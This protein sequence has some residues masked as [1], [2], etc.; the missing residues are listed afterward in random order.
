MKHLFKFLSAALL[1]SAATAIASDCNRDC[2][3][4]EYGERCKC[5]DCGST[6]YLPRPQGSDTA[7]FYNPYYYGCGSCPSDIC[8]AWKLGFRYTQTFDGENIAKCLLGNDS[9]T[10]VGFGTI[11]NPVDQTVAA[12]SKFVRADDFGLSPFYKGTISFEPR[13]KN[14]MIDFDGRWE[15]GN[16]YDCLEGLYFGIQTT[17]AHTSWDWG[18]CRH[19]C[20]TCSKAAPSHVVLNDA[21]ATV[22]VDTMFPQGEMSEATTFDAYRSIPEALQ[23]NRGF[24]GVNGVLG[25]MRYGRF[26]LDDNAEATGLANFDAILG[27]DFLRCDCYHFG[28]FIRASAPTGNRPYS[29][30]IFEPIVGNG[31]H[32]ELGGGLDAHWELWNCDNACIMTYLTGN[33]THLFKDRQT[34]IVPLVSGCCLSQYTLLKEFDDQGLFIGLV[35]GTDVAARRVESSF[36]V[37]GD[38]TLGFIYRNCGWAFGVG[39]NVFG[40]SREKFDDVRATC[41]LNNR[42]FG[43]KG[44]NGVLAPSTLEDTAGTFLST[45]GSTYC[46]TDPLNAAAPIDDTPV[47]VPDTADWYTGTTA[48]DA[49]PTLLSFA[50]TCEMFGVPRM[51]TYKVFGSIDYQW[52][53]CEHKPFFGV[54][55]EAEF[56]NNRNCEVCTANQWGVWVRGGVF[57]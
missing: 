16:W 43:I 15:F 19:E 56:G 39:F 18:L 22:A 55:G 4:G 51:I 24:G 29:L 8:S 45:T 1:I 48:V 6:L 47:A 41:D 36:D 3:Y 23:A 34:R 20:C 52:E 25:P 40:R 9:L 53:E 28:L 35:R 17:L 5:T 32:W 13:I 30:T 21:G 44:R 27:Y 7:Y 37:Q 12:G 54:G 57:F 14:Y 50:T 31:H 42:F 10:F 49:D 11:A 2:N 38:A 33:V 26:V 46:I